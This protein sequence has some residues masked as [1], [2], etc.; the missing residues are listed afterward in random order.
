MRVS[1]Y[2]LRV[3]RRYRTVERKVEDI[4]ARHPAPIIAIDPELVKRGW[5]AR[6]VQIVDGDTVVV[7]DGGVERTIRLAGVD[8]PELGDPSGKGQHAAWM[9]AMWMREFCMGEIVVV[10][11]D[12]RQ[13]L[14]DQYGREVAF[15]IRQPEGSIVNVELVRAGHARA[16]PEH[17]CTLA[18]ELH[19]L[20]VRARTTR[21]GMWAGALTAG[22]VGVSG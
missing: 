21:R 4:L 11:P 20:E 14:L 18:L 5:M 12:P 16:T 17:E 9:A 3:K 6:V 19:E 7:H 13:D 1:P 15:L 2:R 10:V 22:E 8:S